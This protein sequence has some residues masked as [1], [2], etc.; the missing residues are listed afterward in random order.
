MKSFFRRS[1]VLA[2]ALVLSLLGNSVLAPAQSAAPPLDKHSKKIQKKLA[3]YPE[4]SY[5]HL[6]MADAPDAY[7]RL[8][9]MSETGFTFTAA[10]NNAPANLRYSAVEK[11][12]D[13]DQRVGRGAEPIHI[14]HLVPI[15]ITVG[16]AAAGFATYQAIK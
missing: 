14:R 8:G 4:G 13:D 15:L 12:K 10:D 2:F 16:A 3:N 9:T 1:S 11:V 7:G 6:V 5:L